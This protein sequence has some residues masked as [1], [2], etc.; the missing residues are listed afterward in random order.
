MLACRG[1]VTII[2]SSGFV[3]GLLGRRFLAFRDGELEHAVS[4]NDVDVVLESADVDFALFMHN[5][6]ARLDRLLCLGVIFE[7]VEKSKKA[8]LKECADRVRV[9]IFLPHVALVLTAILDNL[10]VLAVHRG[11]HWCRYDESTSKNRGAIS[12]LPRESFFSFFIL[13]IIFFVF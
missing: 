13:F 12:T 6:D 11:G 10:E 8:R 9:A 7:G 2:F 5:S 1:L 4:V 3:A